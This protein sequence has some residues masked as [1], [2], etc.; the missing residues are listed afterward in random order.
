MLKILGTFRIFLIQVSFITCPN[1]LLAAAQNSIDNS[2]TNSPFSQTSLS[3][4]ADALILAKC[5]FII[6]DYHFLRNNYF[7]CMEPF[8][9]CKA[10]VEDHKLQNEQV[11]SKLCDRLGHS[12]FFFGDYEKTRT[13]LLEWHNH[14]IKLF[15]KPQNVYNTL[16]LT[17]AKL[18]DL[19]SSNLFFDL[20][21]DIAIARESKEW[22]GII[23]GNKADNYKKLGMLDEAYKLFYKDYEYSIASGNFISASHVVV[24]LGY[25][26][27]ENEKWDA[28]EANLKEAQ[29][30]YKKSDA[31]LPHHFYT[32][33]GMLYASRDLCTEAFNDFK[34]AN[35][36]KDSMQLIKDNSRLK[37]IEFRLFAEEKEKEIQK[38]NSER[39]KASK[40]SW[41][42]IT[43]LLVF[44]LF[45]GVFIRQEQLKHKKNKS[46]LEY[47]ARLVQEELKNTQDSL[48][49]LMNG[50]NERNEIIKNLD[51][52]IELLNKQNNDDETLAKKEK[53]TEKLQDY[54]LLT[55]DDWTN[56]KKIFNQLHP[57]YLETLT[58]KYPAITNA[59]KRIA[60]LI[61]LNLS[62]SEMANTLGISIDSVR[63]TNLRLRNKLD[64]SSQDELIDYLFSISA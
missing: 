54:R 1:F 13:Y 37:S 53:L 44:L 57:S 59:E 26:N 25:F 60:C 14:P 24:S 63:K 21:L 4:N 50:L 52:E 10:L 43:I 55:E 6:G 35:K 8:L 30:L 20:G 5:Y 47:R 48:S 18:G 22:I 45:I 49:Q 41:T 11:Y 27:A 32:L 58:V 28:V 23:S 56:F 3:E 31:E 36:I 51:Y 7:D 39:E 64:I 38:I 46:I 40:I 9:R 19:D 62:N 12:F 15:N 16:G 29:E 33:R 17:F 2:N 61:R 34:L 42:V